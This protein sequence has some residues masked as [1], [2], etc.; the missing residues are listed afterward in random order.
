MLIDKGD[1]LKALRVISGF[2]AQACAFLGVQFPLDD[3]PQ[4]HRS[5]PFGFIQTLNFDLLQPYIFASLAN[6]KDL[7]GVSADTMDMTVDSAGK[8]RLEST[9]GVRLQV[10]TVRKEVSGYKDHYLGDPSFFRHPGN[11]FEGFD[12]RP[13]KALTIPPLLKDG[14]LLVN[15][16][17][18]TVIWTAESLKP[19]VIQPR[20]AFLRFVAGNGCSEL[21]VSQQGY[22]LAEKEGLGCAMSG[23]GTP[24]ELLAV[25]GQAGTELTQFHAPRL[26]ASLSNVSS[27]TS[28]TDRVE[29]HPREGIVCQ[30]KFNNPQVFPHGATS[31]TWQRGVIFGRTAKFIVDALS[32]TNEE[33][34]VLY[35]VPL[36]NST[37]RLVRGSFEVNFGLV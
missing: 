27:L 35:S 22:W 18:G 3:K 10:H 36:R 2:D 8:L 30:D 33:T 1:Q 4:F 9:E 24:T 31:S 6:L 32:Q 29:L 13:F 25:Y 23:H 15:T 12:I 34:V 7:L 16:I 26:I 5:G 17:A 20:E 11:T 19:V 28:D 14:R 37:Y 21:L